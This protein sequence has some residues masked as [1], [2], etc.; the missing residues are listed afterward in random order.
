[1]GTIAMRRKPPLQTN[2]AVEMPCTH[3]NNR[4]GQGHRSWVMSTDKQVI[5]PTTHV[6]SKCLIRDG[7]QDD[8]Y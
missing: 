8:F 4:P 6:T 3:G 2:P 5:T 7:V 1:M